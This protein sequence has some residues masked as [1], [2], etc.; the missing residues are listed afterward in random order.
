MPPAVNWPA[1]INEALAMLKNARAQGDPL[2]IDLAEASLNDILDRQ[3]VTEKLPIQLPQ[4]SRLPGKG[5]K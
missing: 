5:R 4:L 2:T 3:K 1:R